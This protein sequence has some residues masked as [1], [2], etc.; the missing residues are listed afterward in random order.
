MT[1]EATRQESLSA[2]ELAEQ[3]G[4]PLPDREVM[5]TLPIDDG[6]GALLDLELGNDRPL[7]LDDEGSRP[8]I[9]TQ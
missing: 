3:R 5:S 6:S 8:E 2:E 4:E 7:P 1:D 9:D